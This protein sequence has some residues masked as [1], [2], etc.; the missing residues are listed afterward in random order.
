M[1]EIQFWGSLEGGMRL[2]LQK[3]SDRAN[4]SAVKQMQ[5]LSKKVN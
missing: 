5:K 2:T 4:R 3:Y 1:R